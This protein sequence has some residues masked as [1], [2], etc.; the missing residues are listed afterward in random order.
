MLEELCCKHEVLPFGGPLH[1][2]VTNKDLPK[3]LQVSDGEKESESERWSK[4][5]FQSKLIKQGHSPEMNAASLLAFS[6]AQ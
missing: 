6:V 4:R 2:K 3:T 5:K 1:F